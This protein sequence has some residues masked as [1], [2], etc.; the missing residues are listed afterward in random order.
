MNLLPPQ[1]SLGFRVQL[2]GIVNWN[3]FFTSR[4][5]MAA[6]VFLKHTRQ[7]IARIREIDWENAE[8]L[9]VYLTAV[10]S[11]DSVTTAAK[12]VVGNLRMVK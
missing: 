2:Y 12:N 10:S 5:L 1:G 4:Q 7:A 6:G 9:A 11:G 8:A 3:Q